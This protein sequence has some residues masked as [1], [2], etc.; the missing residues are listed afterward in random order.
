M[1]S[2]PDLLVFGWGKASVVVVEALLRRLH[3][4]PFEFSRCLT[5]HPLRREHP[6]EE[7]G[8]PFYLPLPGRYAVRCLAT[9]IT[10]FLRSQI[11][12]CS[13]AVSSTMVT[14]ACAFSEC[15][16]CSTE[17]ARNIH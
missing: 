16:C 6:G 9:Q 1:R 11:W 5:A 15:Y 10:S 8:R 17:A 4:L 3:S 13:P 12:R 2:V 7:G 14:A